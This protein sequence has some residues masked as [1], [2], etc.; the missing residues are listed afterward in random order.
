MLD[1]AVKAELN[2][3]DQTVLAILVTL[4]VEVC[5]KRNKNNVKGIFG[6]VFP[7]HSGCMNL[8]HGDL[9]IYLLHIIDLVTPHKGILSVLF[10]LATHPDTRTV[11]LSLRYFCRIKEEC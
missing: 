5:M 8:L 11:L 10:L 2:Y 1:Q 6:K 3:I 7:P 4:I 9:V